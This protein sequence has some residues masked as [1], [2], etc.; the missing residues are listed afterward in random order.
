MQ[1]NKP[2][3]LNR[4]G[5]CQSERFPEALSGEYVKIDERSLTD[6]VRQSAKYAN[7]VRYY[8]DRNIEDGNWQAF[9]EE[10]YDY[11]TKQVKFS[12]IEEL[13]SKSSTSPHLALFL[14]FLRLFG[15]AQ[16]NI[17]SLTEK[18]LDFYYKEIL[19]IKPR[20]EK[21]DNIPLFFELNKPA[22]KVTVPAGTLFEAG[23]DKNG[24]PLCY[25]TKKDLIV[26]KAKIGEVKVVYKKGGK[27]YAI[28]N[29]QTAP[30]DDNSGTNDNFL[31]IV[32]DNAH[33]ARFGFAIASKMFHLKEGTRTI[34]IDMDNEFDK[35][36]EYFY[37]KYSSENGWEEVDSFDNNTIVIGPQKPPFV[38]Y[39][40]SVHQA[41]FVTDH[42][43]IRLLKRKDSNF[44]PYPLRIIK[45]TV[46]V[47][48]T[49]DFVVRGDYGV[50]NHRQA[51]LP[52]GHHPV[53]GSTFRIEN[54]NIFNELWITDL[55]DENIKIDW[56][57]PEEL[58]DYYDSYQH[59]IAL[60][61]PE[62]EPEPEPVFN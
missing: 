12:S 18:H 11:E 50:L 8:N 60:G 7:Y 35:L 17:N 59:G 53:K 30:Q 41:G 29:V 56:R 37:V 40:E 21:P 15:I 31:G 13:E 44:V 25:A 4:E 51:F 5:T 54:D 24:K 39:Q 23:K 2:Y 58:K 61:K 28:D 42:P 38:P 47:S 32:E 52:F 20:L 16:E 3:I 1:N 22:Q 55:N 9:F 57:K 49:Q 14:A 10:I 33:Y 48:G 45:L 26:N 36:S 62:P 6:L 34:I 19:R 43:V 46:K 27:I